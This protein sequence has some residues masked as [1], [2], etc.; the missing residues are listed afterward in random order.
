M[1]ILIIVIISIF[2]VFG[3][4]WRL[5]MKRA[6][7]ILLT[8]FRSGNVMVAGHKGTGKDLLFNYVISVRHKAGEIHAA[9]ISYN[10]DTTIRAPV[11][12]C[13]ND[14]TYENFISGKYT[15]ETKKFTEREDYY[16][17]EAGLSL[18]SWMHSKLEKHKRLKL[19]PITMALSRQLG[20]FSVHTNA[21]SFNRVWDKVREQADTFIW[22]ERAKVFKIL[23]LVVQ[24]YV[25]Y[26]RMES[27]LQHIQPFEV[28][29]GI[30]GK[31]KEDLNRAQ[32][33]NAK[34]GYI[35]RFTIVYFYPK[36]STYKTR[37]FYNKLYQ[38][39][40]PS[41]PSKRKLKAKKNAATKL[42]LKP[43]EIIN[44]TQD[45]NENKLPV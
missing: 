31:N 28:R 42:K 32:I 30:F 27:A 9:N 43:E 34:Y 13:L 7:N 14:T 40:P 37:D 16:I 3:L 44:E 18:P 12:Y 41:I 22:T 1:K 21:Q 4:I 33:H 23:K 6:K 25:I 35:E 17:S 20:D 5:K 8:A 2:A 11:E 36:N 26:N 29:R 24:R 39:D 38:K 45:K 10:K 19:L 15:L